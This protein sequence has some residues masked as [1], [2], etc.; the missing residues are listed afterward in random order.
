[1]RKTHT[2]LF[3]ITFSFLF[4]LNTK[5]QINEG[6]TPPSFILK[7]LNQLPFVTMPSIDIAR[8]IA[9]DSINDLNKSMPYRFGENLFTN[10]NPN[11]SGIWDILQDGSKLWRLGIICKEASSINVC[12]DKYKLPKGAKL[13]IYNEEKSFIIG[14]FTEYNNQEDGMFATTLIPGESI[15][16]E[17][18]EPKDVVFKGEINLWRVSHAYRGPYSKTKSFG[19][20]GPCERNV[21]CPETAG[22]ENQIKSVC[23]IIAGGIEL[24][25][26]TLI[27]NTSSNGTPYILTANHCWEAA[28]NP[29]NWVFWFNW[30]SA[31]CTN[32]S[33]NP[34]HQDLSG[35]VLKAKNAETDFCLV[36]MNNT[37]PTNYNVY[38]V[39]W[40]RSTTPSTSAYC[41][42]HPSL[43]IMKF[44]RSLA[45]RDTV[46]YGKI[47]WKARWAYGQVTEPGSSG[48]SIFDQNH[49][50]VG[51]LYGG[52]SSCGAAATDMWDAFG[53]FDVSWEGAGTQETRLKD[54][55]DPTN[56]NPISLGGYDPLEISMINQNNNLNVNIFPNPNNGSFTL[57]INSEKIDNISINIINI[58][59]VSVFEYNNIIVIDN[60]IENF[61]L[62]F[63]PNGVYFIK[64]NCYNNFITKKIIIEK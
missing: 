57:E 33:T 21:V 1:M 62:S 64:V 52:P 32:P 25:S 10:L 20:S 3:V 12:F 2:I 30:K 14:A 41:I 55:L 47:S 23:A 42:H 7:N 61:D 51:Q 6:G 38:Y 9:E 60:Y 49:L 31:T 53:K 39:G 44:S 54:W 35:A 29:S 22:W 46:A 50:L 18:Y 34:P 4:L 26:G 5:A 8:L 36:Q 45:L 28:M 63:L 43:D 17:Y 27:N 59:G 58:I 15:V 37:P 56:S 11:N 16:I 19:S 24:C 48:S 13:F 40:N